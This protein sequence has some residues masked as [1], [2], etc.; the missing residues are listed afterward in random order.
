MA[1]GLLACSIE[2]TPEGGDGD[3]A[4]NLARS[5]DG[6]QR[7]ASGLT[8]ELYGPG[9]AW[10]NYASTTHALTPKDLVYIVKHGE[11]LTLL[12]LL[13]YYD[14]RGESGFFSLRARTHDGE[15]W[16][17][18][19]ERDDGLRIFLT[20]HPSFLLRIP[21]ARDKAAEHERFLA[22]IRAVKQLMAA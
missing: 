7:S 8:P 4:E 1:L 9:S 6:L 17:E 21:D 19:I 22:D 15:R 3:D 20:V 12:E 11:S 10:Y 14:E 18:V 13:D 2:T 16:G 5:G